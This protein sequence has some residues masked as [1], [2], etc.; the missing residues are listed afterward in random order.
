MVTRGAHAL[1]QHQVSKNLLKLENLNVCVDLAK[2]QSKAVI[3]TGRTKCPVCGHRIGK[4]VQVSSY[5][6][7]MC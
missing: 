2:A 7:D 4:H 5:L 6:L 3:I 1:Y